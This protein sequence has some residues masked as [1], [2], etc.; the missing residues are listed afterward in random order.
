MNCLSESIVPFLTPKERDSTYNAK[1]FYESVVRD[2]ENYDILE[3]DS[4]EF[5]LQKQ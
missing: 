5:W 1:L 2:F 4:I 3:Q